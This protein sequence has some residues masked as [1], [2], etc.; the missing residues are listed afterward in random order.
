MKKGFRIISRELLEEDEGMAFVKDAETRTFKSKD[1]QMIY[2]I[3]ITMS[4][5]LSISVDSQIEFI[6]KNVSDVVSKIIPTRA[7]YNKGKKKKK[8]YE[9]IKGNALLLVTL[10]YLIITIQTMTPSIITSKTFP[11]CKRSFKGYPYDGD[12]NMSFLTYIS[13]IVNNISLKSV[14]WITLKRKKKKRGKTSTNL[15]KKASKY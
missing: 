2:N 11:G 3:I 6:I 12:G 4:R 10:C 15:N 13:C 1:A 7:K 8:P 5:Y 9:H 14:P